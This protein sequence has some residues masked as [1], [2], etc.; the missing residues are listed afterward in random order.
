MLLTFAAHRLCLAA[1]GIGGLSFDA[2][3]APVQTRY[4]ENNY[5]HWLWAWLSLDW[6][7]SYVHHLEVSSLVG[8]AF[9]TTTWIALL[10]IVMAYSG[11]LI[12]GLYAAA[13]RDQWSDRLLNAW[14]LFL[15]TIPSYMTGL[16]LMLVFATNLW[17]GLAVLC[18]AYPMLARLVRFVRRRALDVMS[19]DFVTMSLARGLPQSIVMQRH[20]LPHVVL[21][22]LGLLAVDVPY[23]LSGSVLLESIFRVRGLGLLAYEALLQRDFQVLLAIVALAALL[24]LLVSFLTER[25]TLRIVH[26]T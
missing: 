26:D 10:A 24:T 2:S 13:H 3:V 4:F 7:R 22:L 15:G 1:P 18:L 19:K 5:W 21:P 12:L 16:L 25:A 11:G 14:L 20:V 9:L 8:A 17:W 6:G 23:L